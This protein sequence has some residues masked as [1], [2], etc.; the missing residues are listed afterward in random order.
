MPDP[1][2]HGM[3]SSNDLIVARC[4]YRFRGAPVIS[5]GVLRFP[6]GS[7]H[8]LAY[9]AASG[10]AAGSLQAALARYGFPVRARLGIGM[11]R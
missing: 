6:E 2:V 11:A 7:E 9:S 4:Y 5:P 8:I 1:R 3:H 10:A